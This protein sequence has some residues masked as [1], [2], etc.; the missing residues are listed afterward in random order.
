MR[1]GKG[2]WVVDGVKHSVFFEAHG[3]WAIYTVD[4]MGIRRSVKTISTR[5]EYCPLCGRHVDIV[6]DYS[7]DIPA[8]ILA[9]FRG[10]RAYLARAIN[11][12]CWMQQPAGAG[13]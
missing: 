13:A 4:E 2:Y 5:G 3:Q 1:I 11:H 12:G 6:G 8:Q 10:L 9:Q 7:P